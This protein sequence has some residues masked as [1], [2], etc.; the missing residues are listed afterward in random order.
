MQALRDHWA[1][2]VRN[3][4]R[5]RAFSHRLQE[6]NPQPIEDDPFL[7]CP[8]NAPSLELTRQHA[9]ERPQPPA[10]LRNPPKRV[11]GARRGTHVPAPPAGAMTAGWRGGA[12]AAAAVAAAADGRRALGRAGPHGPGPQ[13]GPPSGSPGEGRPWS[14]AGNDAMHALP[15]DSTWLRV[16]RARG[17]NR[18][19]AGRRGGR[20]WTYASAGI[21]CVAYG[22]APPRPKARRKMQ[23][24]RTSSTTASTR[25]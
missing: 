3:A 8:S 18:V 1:E 7:V 12:L 2:I 5:H 16:L 11:A 6:R 21:S 9:Y 17:R 23:R 14:Q 19:R 15:D 22:H 24:T 10:A 4:E 25:S 13:P 20:G